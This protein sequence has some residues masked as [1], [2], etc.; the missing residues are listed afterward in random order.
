MCILVTNKSISSYHFP[1]LRHH[2]NGNKLF[3]VIIHK[4]GKENDMF[5]NLLNTYRD[6]QVL[7]DD[8][9]RLQL[10]KSPEMAEAKKN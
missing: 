10:R 9:R 1:I 5:T 2:Y 3:K 6:G 4:A 7:G 8:Q